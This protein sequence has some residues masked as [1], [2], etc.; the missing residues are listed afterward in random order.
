VKKLLVALA[1]VAMA[2]LLPALPASADTTG[3]SSTAPS[4]VRGT[5]TDLAPS[6]ACSVSP[7]HYCVNVRFVSVA[8]GIRVTRTA[9]TGYTTGAGK[10]REWFRYSCSAGTCFI[11][12]SVIFHYTRQDVQLNVTR[13]FSGSGFFLPCGNRFGV[14]YIN[15]AVNAPGPGALL[16]RVTCT[17]G[18]GRLARTA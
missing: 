13:T 2:L 8:N 6:I 15:P 7:G 18:A 4:Q 5:V 11:L 1:A 16:F 9:S 10:G 17:N 14:D 3:A 12:P